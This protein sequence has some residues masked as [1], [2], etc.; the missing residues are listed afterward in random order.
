ME[1][2]L[3]MKIPAPL[4]DVVGKLLLGSANW[5]EKMKRQLGL[6]EE[7]PNL[8]EL[9]RL[10]WRPSQ[11]EVERAVAEEFDV[12]V[13]QLHQKRE[14]RNE[15]REAAFYLIRKLTSVPANQLATQ[16]GPVSPSAI[17]KTIQR[18]ALRCQE[19]Q[20]WKKRL[21]T[22]EKRLQEGTTSST[23]RR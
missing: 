11:E 16:Y 12:D 20:S 10:D 13:V 21:R 5:V 14:Q 19:K 23:S 22:L 15:A 7:D 1:A 8:P 6:T 9:R 2:G 18:A 3:H 4:K 17:S